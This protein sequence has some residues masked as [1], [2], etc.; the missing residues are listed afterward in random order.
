MKQIK[1][2]NK[3]YNKKFIKYFVLHSTYYFLML[4]TNFTIVYRSNI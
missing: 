3:L 4:L 1:M 2:K